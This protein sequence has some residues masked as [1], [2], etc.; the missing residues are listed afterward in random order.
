MGLFAGVEVALLLHRADGSHETSPYGAL[1]GDSEY[2]RP[3]LAVFV[4]G[5]AG[6]ERLLSTQGEEGAYGG[7]ASRVF[8]HAGGRRIQIGDLHRWHVQVQVLCQLCG[9]LLEM[10]GHG[11]RETPG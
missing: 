7:D 11:P 2:E 8:R 1:G 6:V 5:E 3:N 4:L 9:D 10:L